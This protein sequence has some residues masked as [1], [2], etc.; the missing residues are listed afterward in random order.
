MY[1]RRGKRR[2]WI[3]RVRDAN[4][5]RQSKSF[6]RR[7]DA[8]EYEALVL[9][10]RER[11]R[12]GLERPLIPTPFKDYTDA[13]I[14]KRMQTHP[15]STWSGERGKLERVWNPLLGPRLL[16]TITGAE[17]NRELDRLT[18]QDKI[19]PATRNRHRSL[20]HTIFES[21]AKDK[22]IG[23]GMNPAS[24]IQILTEGRKQIDLWHTTEESDTYTRAGFDKAPVYGV[25]AT[26]QLWLGCRI[27]ETLALQWRDID[28]GNHRVQIRRIAE[29]VSREIF[30]RT[31]G[32]KAGDPHNAPLFPRVAAVLRDWQAVTAHKEPTDFILCDEV[33]KPFTYWQILRVHRA[34]LKRAGLKR[35]TIHDLRHVYASNA[36][37]IGF[38]KGE[39][40]RMLGHASITTTEIYTH[41]GTDHLIE[42]AKR[43]GF[44]SGLRLVDNGRPE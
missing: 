13:W 20:L 6:T 16:H 5:R 31:K 8:V 12:S 4:G 3:V 24:D 35:I 1:H 37:K 14:A 15:K 19:G 11:V 26:L 33:G 2:P 42:K 25:Y 23:A 27:S 28:W 30:D 29:T 22:L 9:R 7:E 34:L 18:T 36:E 44:A 40:Q 38:S 32:E 39:I 10:T 43:L 41:M 17:L 21:A